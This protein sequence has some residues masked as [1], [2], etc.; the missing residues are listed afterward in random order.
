MI[1]SPSM[2]TVFSVDTMV[3]WKSSGPSVPCS[4]SKQ[5]RDRGPREKQHA[6]CGLGVRW[7]EGHNR[8]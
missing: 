3:L 7:G 2:M 6:M 1:N 4:T 5:C 8:G